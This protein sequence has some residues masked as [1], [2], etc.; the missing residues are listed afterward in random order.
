MLKWMWLQLSVSL[1]HNLRRL[2]SPN[3]SDGYTSRHSNLGPSR[4][5]GDKQRAPRDRE[6]PPFRNYIIKITHTHTH[7]MTNPLAAIILLPRLT[8]A[9]LHR[10]GLVP[11]LVQGAGGS[12][13]PSYHS[14]PL[15]SVCA[16]VCPINQSIYSKASVPSFFHISSLT[17]RHLG[18][19]PSASAVELSDRRE[20]LPDPFSIIRGSPEYA[21]VQKFYTGGW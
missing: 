8:A 15:H 19:S 7:T 11:T 6:S 10:P 16:L 4:E 5:D 1:T 18:R 2:T 3:S 17:V 9:V 12:P 21:L 13:A 14:R 20:Q